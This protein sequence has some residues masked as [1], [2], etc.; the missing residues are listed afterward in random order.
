MTSKTA[1]TLKGIALKHLNSEGKMLAVG[2]SEDPEG[3]YNN[4]ALYPQM[5]PWLFPYGYGGIGCETEIKISEKEHK[6]HLLMYHDKRFQTDMFF[7]FVAFSHEQIKAASTGGYLITE[8]AN[9]QQ[10]SQRLLNLN[11]PVLNGL[12]DRLAAGQV[13]HPETQEEKDCYQVIRDLDHIGSHV[14]GSTTSKKYMRNEIWSLISAKGPPT[15]FITLSPADV[16]HPICIYYADTQKVFQPK[17]LSHPERFRLISRNPVA[18]ARFFHLMVT[19]FI[20]HIL[21]VGTDHLGVY[22]QTAAYYGT[23]EQQE[24]DF[25]TK[26]DSFRGK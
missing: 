11:I 23:V 9:F 22:G 15:W 8:K 4:P 17:I 24:T 10:M 13:V 19:L 26:M 16:K 14:Q 3:I 6:R 25:R 1:E 20:Q 2:H 18:A 7:P 12:A 5:F 21:G